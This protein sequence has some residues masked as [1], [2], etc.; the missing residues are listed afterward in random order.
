[1]ARVLSSFR[2]S[3]VVFPV[4]VLQTIPRLLESP[5]LENVHAKVVSCGARHSAIITGAPLSS[6]AQAFYNELFFSFLFSFSLSFFLLGMISYT[7]GPYS[8]CPKG[9][10]TLNKFC[11]LST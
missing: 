9:I 3:D 2:R 4:Y 11:T 1:M 8:I 7:Y 6:F 5:S 10:K